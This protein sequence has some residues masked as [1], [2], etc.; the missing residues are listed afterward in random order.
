MG[1]LYGI[2]SMIG[3]GTADFLGANSSRKI[4]HFLTLFWMQFIGT[5]VAF[6]Y[7]I[8]KANNLDKTLFYKYLPLL[9]IIAILQTIAYL[10]FYKGFEKGN[11]SVVSPIASSWAMVTIILSILFLGE[12]INSIQ[13]IGIILILSGIILISTDIKEVSAM[14]KLKIFTGVKEGI[15]AMLGWGVSFFLIV[16]ATRDLG[17]FFPIFIFKVFAVL[18]L[19]ILALTRKRKLYP[20]GSQ[21][22][23]I[24][25]VIPIGL[26]DVT[27]FFSYNFG[28][29][30]SLSLIISPVA[31][32]FPVITVL[33]ARIFLKERLRTIQILGIISVI[34]GIILL[35]V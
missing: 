23:F 10:S 27:S 33:L 34:G 11:V 12:A 8:T 21:L 16:P 28:L 7:F 26:L 1:I 18:F 20:A 13:L 24:S 17:W 35:S 31:A 25:L 3:W 19:L 4:G 5:S 29:E 30:G 15:I 14:R 32:S 6:I 22:S 2:L 9:G